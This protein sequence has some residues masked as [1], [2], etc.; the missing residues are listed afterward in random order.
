VDFSASGFSA[1]LAAQEKLRSG[2]KGLDFEPDLNQNSAASGPGP[3][4]VKK[5]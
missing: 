2:F 3:G 4:Y 5:P 1:L